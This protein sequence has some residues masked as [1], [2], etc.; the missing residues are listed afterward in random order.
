LI[1]YKWDAVLHTAE[2]IPMKWIGLGVTS[3]WSFDP[4]DFIRRVNEA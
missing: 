2:T 4:D 1:H 3:G